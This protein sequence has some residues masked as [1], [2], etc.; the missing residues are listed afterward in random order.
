[1]RTVLRTLWVTL[2]LMVATLTIGAIAIAIGVTRHEGPIYWTL[3]RIWC[4][5]LLWASGT[6]VLMEGIEHLEV[7]RPQILVSNH[8]S[9]YDVLAI[10][11]AVPKHFRFVA[12]KELARIP[13]FGLAWRLAGHISI[14]RSDRMSAIQSL[15]RAGEVLRADNSIVVIFPEGTRSPTG[16]L[17]PF[18]KGAFMLALGAGVEIVPAAVVGSRRVLAKG[19]WLVHPGPIILRIGAPISSDE[20]DEAMREEL[21]EVVRERVLELRDGVPSAAA[22]VTH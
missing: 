6:P 8:T 16:D 11:A 15:A 12:K 20:Y 22:A 1:M 14:D 18:K 21:V 10:G 17:L 3:S 9:W 2:N 19:D 5:W 13:V 4:R 7:G